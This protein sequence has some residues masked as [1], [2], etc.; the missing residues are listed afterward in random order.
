MLRNRYTPPAGDRTIGIEGVFAPVAIRKYNMCST[1]N[2]GRFAFCVAVCLS[3]LWSSPSWGEQELTGTIAS[4]SLDINSSLELGTLSG[5]TCRSGG[6]LTLIGSTGTFSSG[7]SCY[8]IINSGPLPTS[9]NTGNYVI[10]SNTAFV[11]DTMTIDVQP[12]D[13]VLVINGQVIGDVVILN[14]TVGGTGRV[15]NLTNDGGVLAPGN[16]IGTITVTGDYTHNE[17]ATLEIEINGA[18]ASD[19]VNVSGEAIING[20][21]VQVLPEDTLYTD[22]TYTFLTAAGGVTGEFDSL[23][24][25]NML[26][27]D[28][29]LIY[30]PTSVQLR[31]DHSYAKVAQTFNQRA[32]GNYLNDHASYIIGSGLTS[33]TTSQQ[34][35][36]ALDSLSGELYGSLST[37]GIENTGNFLQTIA[38]RLRARS[39]GQRFVYVMPRIEEAREAEEEE[40]ATVV[41]RGQDVLGWTTRRLNRIMPWGEGYGVSAQ[42]GSDGNAGGLDYSTG[43][44][45]FGLEQNFNENLLVGVMGGY[46]Q[47]S[48]NFDRQ[49]D[50]STINAAQT[51]L[52]LQYDNGVVY[53]TGIAAYGYNDYET[54]RHILPESMVYESRKEYNGNEFSFYLETGRNFYPR[55]VYLQPFVA[56]QYIQ[57]HQNKIRERD[58]ELTNLWIGGINADSFRGLLGL[59]AVRDFQLPGYRLLSLEGRVLWRHEFLDEARLVD[60]R[61]AS[62]PG[63]SFTV[64]GVSVDRD[65]AILGGGL[66]FCLRTGAE[67]YAN[68]DLL[69][70]QNYTAHTGTGGLTLMW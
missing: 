70:S 22:R 20:G 11:V 5:G 9:S 53:T 1:T 32:V 18:G 48:V 26:F 59:R 31:V 62:Y 4:G 61:L 3:L 40:E 37:V 42:I 13:G 16:S 17:D 35:C 2:F 27:Y 6:T 30:N 54:R 64:Q 34:V 12:G 45:A 43:G 66:T 10:D 57:L 55:F 67:I 58:A 39:L 33:L 15:V 23:V 65:V 29:W 36:D 52:Y 7:D 69:I 21:T 41:I 25:E 60:A 56:L 50:W 47:T 49:D 63:S 24:T 68:Y 38:T 44:T 14:G 8:S 19:L 28:T 51:G 46:S